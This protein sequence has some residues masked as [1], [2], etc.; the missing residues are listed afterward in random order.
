MAIVMKIFPSGE[1]GGGIGMY[2]SDE[3]GG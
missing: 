2:I 1:E 3:S